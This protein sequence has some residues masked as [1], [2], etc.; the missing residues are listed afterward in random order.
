MDRLTRSIVGYGVVV[1]GTVTLV[2]VALPWPLRWLHVIGV[3]AAFLVPG[4]VQGILWREFFRGRRAMDQNLMADALVHFGRFEERLIKQPWVA[5]GLYLGSSSYTWSAEAMLANNIG[6][7]ELALGNLD[8]AEAKFEQAVRRDSGYPVPYFNLAV[9]AETRRDGERAQ[10]LLADAW[11]RG[12][13]GGTRER[14]VAMAGS[15]LATVEGR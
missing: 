12:F 15:V 6:A 4:R 14:V 3:A 9:V 2:L 5:A 13:R 10:R 11:A 8:A 1:G 7:C